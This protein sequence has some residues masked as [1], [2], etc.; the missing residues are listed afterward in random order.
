[1]EYPDK[2]VSLVN[3]IYTTEDQY[4]QF[5][6]QGYPHAQ[7]L[8]VGKACNIDLSTTRGKGCYE[9]EYMHNAVQWK[10]NID[11]KVESLDVKDWRESRSIGE[12]NYNPLYPYRG[13][14]NI[15]AKRAESGEVINRGASATWCAYQNLM[16]KICHYPSKS[17]HIDFHQSSFVTALSSIPS[18]VDVYSVDVDNS[19]KIRCGELFNQPYFQSFPIT[20]VACGRFIKD[21]HVDI[22]SVFNQKYESMI[23]DGGDWMRLYKNGNRLLIHTK[24]ISLCSESLLETI[25]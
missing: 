22:E 25:A 1:M 2:F 8:L 11:K 15:K 19:V 12:D 23:E 9:M 7:I 3:K 5:I 21:Y 17:S 13:V 16:E 10:N 24:P 14:N 18:P 4:V 20:I 6:G